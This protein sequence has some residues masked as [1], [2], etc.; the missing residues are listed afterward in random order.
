MKLSRAA[1]AAYVCLVFVS[2]GAL[3]AFGMRLWIAQST[4]RRPRPNPEE[5]RKRVVAEYESR[6]KLNP[7]QVLKLN[8]IMDETKAGVDEVRRRQHPE[9]Q[10][11]HENQV[12]KIHDMLTPEQ[13]QEFEKMMKE[14]EQHERQGGGRGPGGI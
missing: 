9:Y 2:G 3:G 4:S 6:L 1:I 10:K 14:R 13:Q 11:I 5:Q 8:I 7:E 12:H